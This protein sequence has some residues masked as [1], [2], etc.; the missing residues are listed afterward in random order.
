MS[1]Y[2]CVEDNFYGATIEDGK[3]VTEMT[4]KWAETGVSVK[5]IVPWVEIQHDIPVESTTGLPVKIKNGFYFGLAK[6]LRCARFE[7]YLLRTSGD[8]LIEWQA[9]EFI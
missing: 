3:L 1:L 5:T 9:D 2:Q 7:K 4:L 8:D 6:R